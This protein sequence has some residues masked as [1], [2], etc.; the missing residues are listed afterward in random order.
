ML[1]FFDETFRKHRAGTSF[2][3]LCGIAIPEELFGTVI[4]DVYHLKHGSMGE[5]FAKEREL[6]GTKLLKNRNLT[7]LQSGSR[8]PEVDL[9]FDILRYVRRQKFVTFGVV[10]FRAEFRTF[11]CADPHSLELPYRALFERID[12]YMKREY[13]DRMAK[14]VFDDVDFSA[15]AN[16][17]ESITN[18]FNRTAIGRG[19][20][21]IIRT[22][23]FSV[24]QAQN[25]GLQLA[26]VVTTVY[27]L[28]FQGD[29]RVKPLF[30]I[31]K[32]TIY[33]YRL[34]SSAASTLRTLR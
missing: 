29:A 8:R 31:L 6:K 23:F 21:Q 24:S 13:P 1:I 10:C 4:V 34:G 11:R 28:R 27:G 2:G 30:D 14:V 19:F 16:R 3:A 25:V 22:P 18:F 20:D 5:Q 26:D 32:S 15:N 9:V 12:S 7:L 33:R 17:A